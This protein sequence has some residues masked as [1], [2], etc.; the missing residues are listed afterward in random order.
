MKRILASL[1]LVAFITLALY[2]SV[3]TAQTSYSINQVDHTIAILYSGNMVV[4]AT[5]H[6]S[7]I[8]QDGFLIAL[9]YIY[10]ADVL[11]VLAYD[12]THVYNV[13]VG[14]P[15]PN[16]S[17]FYGVS[18]DFNGATPSEFTV[19]FVLS[20]RL[21]TDQG[22]GNFLIEFPAYPSLT[23]TAKVVN[24]NVVCP[25]AP[26]SISI[27]KEDTNTTTTSYRKNDL[28]PYT[29]SIASANI[30][31]PSGTLETVT[32]PALYRSI[33]VDATGAVRAADTYQLASN[34]SSDLN[35]F[36]LSLPLDATDITVKDSADVTLQS[37]VV[38]SSDIQL[39]N[40]TF[41]APLAPKEA[42]ALTVQY[43]LP[44]AVLR[45][46]QYMLPDFQL[47]TKYPY[48]VQYATITFI[49]P[50]GAT[51]T[52][53]A[54]SEMDS[55][56][57]LIRNIYQDI[58]TVRASDISYVDALAPQ[59]N[60][61]LSYNYNPVWVSFGATFYASLAGVLVSV[62]AVVYRRQRPKQTYLTRPKPADLKASKVE[63]PVYE[64]IKGAQVT[65]DMLREFT[66]AYEDKKQLTA[67]LHA[68]DMK[69]L[70]D[71]ISR[72]QYKAQRAALENRIDSVTRIIER[73]KALFRGASGVYADLIKQLD[74]AE[75]DLAYAQ[76]TL[77]AFELRLSKGEISLETYKKAV[78]DPQ[79][80][81]RQ[82]ELAI[83][84]I[85]LKLREK[86]R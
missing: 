29:Y 64:T 16:Q 79:K 40:A 25:T 1:L 33:T 11:K 7:G 35:S 57:T 62:G 28:S 74:L 27:Q 70:R 14:V 77:N 20:N 34:A 23:Q 60:T 43:N 52:S 24:V 32:V 46:S 9:P 15:L 37:S 42:T 50:E 48:V 59:E 49:L 78:V 80:T 66:D 84:G 68:L 85:L 19:A 31:V 81:R 86:I 30:Q 54:A 4:L 82:A 8:V 13:K 45:G 53:P 12:S 73:N 83:N 75:A 36:V 10:S 63:A 65:P 38:P 44:G 18:V 67:Q 76:E 41:S 22:N 51:I 69:G 58:L 72:R 5:V 55:S 2:P 6:V 26:I 47:F 56:A 71:K 39:V 21:T 3:V 61:W 17:G